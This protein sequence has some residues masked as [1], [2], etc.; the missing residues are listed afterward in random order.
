MTRERDI[1]RVL[2]AWLEPGPT[3]APDRILEALVDRIEHVPQRRLPRAHAR[4]QP[5]TS[6]FKLAAAAALLLTIGIVLAPFATPTNVAEPTPSPT[7]PPTILSEGL[8]Y[9]WTHVP[10]T[11][12]PAGQAVVIQFSGEEFAIHR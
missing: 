6:V 7:P 9:R 3:E 2:E 1:G 11:G 4:F 10:I 5:M 12:A 8:R